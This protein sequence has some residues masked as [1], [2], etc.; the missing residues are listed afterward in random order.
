MIQ[1]TVAAEV[2]ENGAQQQHPALLQPVIRRVG[3]KAN[4]SSACGPCKRAHLACDPARPC[5][6]CVNIGKE[7]QCEDVPHKKRGRPKV[8]KTPSVDP[9]ARPAQRPAPPP[10]SV[11]DDRKWRPPTNYDSP[12]STTSPPVQLGSLAPRMPS[13]PRTAMVAPPGSYDSAAQSPYSAQPP[14]SVSA[15]TIAHPSAL[16]PFTLFCST[17]LKILRASADCYEYLG[18]HPHELL[19]LDLLRWIHTTDHHLINQIRDQLLNVSYLP[20]P[21]HTSRETYVAIVTANEQELKSPAPGMGDPFPHQTVRMFH[22]DG[23]IYPF[24]VRMHL[25]GGLGGSLWQKDTLGKIYLVV[26]CLPV[27]SDSLQD[28]QGRRPSHYASAPPAPAPP[29]PSGALPSFSSIA[30]AADSPGAQTYHRPPS[31]PGQ[32]GPYYSRPS[33]SSSTPYPPGHS[34]LSPRAPSPGGHGSYSRYHSYPPPHGQPGYYLPTSGPYDRRLD[35][36][37][38]EWRRHGHPLP[39]PGALGSG[40]PPPDY[41]RGWDRQ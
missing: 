15:H 7:D 23:M 29:P 27:P 26:S 39:P 11:V 16:G 37:P 13:P 40:A 18:F 9:Y 2:V 12:Y 20:T 17:D 19:N 5:K 31:A 8:N 21:P 3:N 34:G 33:T 25:G 35:A 24:N 30:A 6:R 14:A 22:G 41:H 1:R 28:P 32:S 4:V 36:H 10:P 38:D